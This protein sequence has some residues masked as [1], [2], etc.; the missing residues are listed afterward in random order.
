MRVFIFL[1]FFLI[2][3]CS[4]DDKSGIWKNENVISKKEK[5]I[6]E[7]FET[8]KSEKKIFEENIR[9]RDNFTFA[10]ISQIE[11]NDWRDEFYSAS[12]NLVNFKY[13]NLNELRFKGKKISRSKLNNKFLLYKNL[14]FS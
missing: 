11:N 4:F 3:S 1:F 6:F 2:I 7:G 5:K 14:I 13:K 12:N 8:F 10:S 9:L